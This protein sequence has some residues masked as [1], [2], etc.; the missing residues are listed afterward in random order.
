MRATQRAGRILIVDDDPAILTVLREIFELE[1]YEATEARNGE[2]MRRELSQ[3]TFDLITLDLGL[4]G[5]SGLDLAR[6]V[7]KTSNIP[8][9]I[10][11]ARC[12]DVDRI[13]GLEVGADDYIVKPF[14]AREVV[15]RVRAVLRR[16]GSPSYSHETEQGG[17]PTF[18]TFQNYK[19][20]TQT[21][22]LTDT[23]GATSILTAAECDLL[24]YLLKNAGRPCSRDQITNVLKGHEWSPFDRSLDTLVKRL[25]NKLEPNPHKPTLLLSV[26]GVGYKLAT[27]AANH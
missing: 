16:C 27:D 2:D 26:R 1:D 25:R 4:A 23:N 6:E 11:S 14:S 21:R 5:T 19:F 7:R 18:Y 12:S 3:S 20:S 15:A 17:D 13:V 22:K 8:I 10:V 9:I 24:E